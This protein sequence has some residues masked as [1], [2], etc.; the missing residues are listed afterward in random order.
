MGSLF[1]PRVGY[2]CYPR[3]GCLCHLLMGFFAYPRVGTFSLRGGG[4]RCFLYGAK[5]KAFVSLLLVSNTP[6]YTD[7]YTR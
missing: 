4:E 3:V 2:L 7:D 6:I 1:Y 5:K